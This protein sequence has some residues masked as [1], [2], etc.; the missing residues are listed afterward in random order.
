M[1]RSLNSKE[2]IT[3]QFWWIK[4]QQYEVEGDAT[5]TLKAI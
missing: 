1:I 2:Y 4:E 5:P 3:A